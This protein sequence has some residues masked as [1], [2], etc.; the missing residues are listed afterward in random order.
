MKFIWLVRV[1]PLLNLIFLETISRIE[2][3]MWGKMCPK[4]SFLAFIQPVWRF[5]GKN[6]KAVFDT[7]FPIEKVI[8]IFVV[9]HH[10]S[11]K[12][13][14]ASQKLFFAVILENIV[15]CFFFENIVKWKIFTTSFLIKKF[16]FIF[17]ARH[18]LPLKM[19]I[20]SHK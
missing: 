20:S 14:H 19:V 16:I 3:L 11:L 18:P 8:F 5:W 7:S 9:R 6:F 4:T 10:H 13:G 15:F 1:L 12:N 2:P 17:V